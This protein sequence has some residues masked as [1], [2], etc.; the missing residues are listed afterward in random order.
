M[1]DF[2]VGG[3]SFAS[4]AKAIVDSG[5]SIMTGPAAEVQKIADKIGAKAFVSGEY[6]VACDVTE[7]M[8]IVIGGKT[9]TLTP[10]DYLIPDG[11]IC[12][13]GLMALDIPGNG[14]ASPLCST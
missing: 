13:L 14:C 2:Q 3:T 11:D 6:L 8:D 7:N 4:S 12:L 5:T 10:A 1:D 9:Y